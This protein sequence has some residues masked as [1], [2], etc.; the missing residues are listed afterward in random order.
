MRGRVLTCVVLSLSRVQGNKEKK[1]G[2]EKKPVARET[3]LIG[4]RK[5][6]AALGLGDAVLDYRG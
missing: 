5:A 6:A 3:R 1:V 4:K 2:E